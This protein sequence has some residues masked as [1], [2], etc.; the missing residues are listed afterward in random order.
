MPPAQAVS[1]FSE[2]AEPMLLLMHNLH[3]QNRNL[4]AQRDLLLP[5]LISG[6]IDVSAAERVME[7]AE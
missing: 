2:I 4:R 5:K 3:R 7:A 1:K 6:E